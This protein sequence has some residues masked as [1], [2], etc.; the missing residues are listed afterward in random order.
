MP[1]P[2]KYNTDEERRAAIRQASLKYYNKNREALNAR[3]VK[4][5]K[6]KRGAIKAAQK[7]PSAG[8]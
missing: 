5:R 6:S 8:A 1:R 3:R 4:A 7:E 2:R